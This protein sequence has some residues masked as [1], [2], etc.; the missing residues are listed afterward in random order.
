MEARTPRPWFVHIA[1]AA[2]LL[3]TGD[4][5]GALSAMERSER[6]SGAMWAMYIPLGDPVFDPIRNSGRFAAL[7]RRSNLDLRIVTAPRRRN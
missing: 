7:L 4:S 3:A 5:A 1:K 6:T 2:V